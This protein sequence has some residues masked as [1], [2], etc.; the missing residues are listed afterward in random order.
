MLGGSENLI[1]GV[2]G[3]GCIVLGLLSWIWTLVLAFKC[4]DFGMAILGIFIPVL[5]LMYQIM[6]PIRC[7]VPLAAS[8]TFAALFALGWN[9]SP[10]GESKDVEDWLNSKKDQL[11]RGEAASTTPTATPPAPT[12]AVPPQN[13]NWEVTNE[14]DEDN[15][16]KK[17]KV[18]VARSQHQTSNRGVITIKATCQPTV[19]LALEFDSF[20][21]ASQGLAY[22][23][24]DD[25]D[26]SDSHLAI[27]YR[28]D[29]GDRLLALN[30][31]EEL[32]Y[33]NVSKVTFARVGQDY[34]APSLDK[35]E[36]K[37]K[38]SKDKDSNVFVDAFLGTLEIG[39]LA[40]VA[41]S[42]Q[43]ID[44]LLKGRLVE[45]QLPLQGGLKEIVPI[46]PRD[47]SFKQ[48]LS[49][50]SLAAAAC[51][52]EAKQYDSSKV[53]WQGK[54]SVASSKKTGRT[55]DDQIEI[56]V[57]SGAQMWVKKNDFDERVG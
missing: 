15:P 52:V 32:K 28:I 4:R 14:V 19:S 42:P 23:Y 1:L 6:H 7:K 43:D 54:G 33:T 21:S 24:A 17:E 26:G 39:A 27:I 31:L 25:K 5:A 9:L 40:L 16:I 8:L 22:E 53:S 37:S 18:W 57:P 13:I 12:T 29:D 2:C 47:S 30:S 45:F 35:M 55:A 34:H 44:P 11:S 46:Y 38:Q 56:A 10:P 51:S 20:T 50:C 36:A 49:A 3:I 41:E 48:F